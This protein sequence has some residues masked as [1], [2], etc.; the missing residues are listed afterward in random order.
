[1]VVAGSVAGWM[2]SKSTSLILCNVEGNVSMTTILVAF[3]QYKYRH[4]MERASR[5][6]CKLRGSYRQ[7]LRG[8]S[9]VYLCLSR[10]IVD[11]LCYSLSSAAGCGI[12]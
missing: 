12:F 8:I 3:T 5:F 4:I 6:V 9:V 11:V 2:G 10:S 7:H 1:M